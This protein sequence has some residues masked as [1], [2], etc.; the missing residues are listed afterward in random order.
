MCDASA[1][2]LIFV[3][4]VGFDSSRIDDEICQWINVL[5]LL[6]AAFYVIRCHLVHGIQTIWRCLSV[7][8]VLWCTSF[9]CATPSIAAMA[10]VHSLKNAHSQLHITIKWSI[11]IWSA[12]C[13]LL[14]CS[15]SFSIWIQL[16]FITVR[17]Y[18][19]SLVMLTNASTNTISSLCRNGIKGIRFFSCFFF[20]FKVPLSLRI[21]HWASLVIYYSHLKELMYCVRSMVAVVVIVAT[22]YTFRN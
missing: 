7:G 5:L 15:P 20:L 13:A 2:F 8:I 1:C 9:H 4:F 22:F 18:T 10:A 17:F 21:L 12:M 16:I 14:F 11:K 3:Y 19:E 6:F